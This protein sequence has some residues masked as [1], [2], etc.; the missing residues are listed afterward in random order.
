MAAVEDI[1]IRQ[2]ES[3]AL[4]A[5]ARHLDTARKHLK[6]SLQAANQMLGSIPSKG[7][8]DFESLVRFRLLA[9]SENVTN[10]ERTIADVAQQL[11]A[12]KYPALQSCLAIMKAMDDVSASMKVNALTHKAEGF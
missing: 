9:Q 6:D 4:A 5:S 1:D 12:G 8:K 2:P 11:Q 7:S 3:K 10:L